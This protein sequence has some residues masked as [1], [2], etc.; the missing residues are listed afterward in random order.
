MFRIFLLLILVFT[1]LSCSTQRNLDFS[2][3]I[4]FEYSH[5]GHAW[6]EKVVPDRWVTEGPWPGPED[7]SDSLA[8]HALYRAELK[9]MNSGTVLYAT[10]FNS[11]FG[12]YKTT[13]DGLDSVVQIFRES[14]R[15]PKPVVS[16]DLVL[17]VW[18]DSLGIFHPMLSLRVPDS[19][20]VPFSPPVRQ[21]GRDFFLSGEP[22]GK[23]DV[24]ILGDGY[25][26]ADTAKFFN[27]AG[28]L[29]GH[30]FNT[31]PFLSMKDRF[32]L[33]AAM[34]PSET[35]GI[36]DPVNQKWAQGPLGF[37][38]NFFN[39]DRYI[40]S[41]DPGMIMNLAASYPWDVLLVLV[42]SRKYGGG[43][44]YNLYAVSASDNEQSPYVFIHEFGHSFAG[45][46]DEYYTS[47]I[48]YVVKA[49][50]EPREPNLSSLPGGRPKWESLLS[51]GVRIPTPWNQSGYDSAMVEIQKK[52]RELTAS[53][54][55][56]SE[57]EALFRHEKQ[58]TRFFLSPD[59]LMGITGAFEGGGYLAKGVY[60]PE[61][62]CIMFSRN[63]PAFCKVCES[64]IRKRIEK[65]S[66]N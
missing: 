42:N 19:G 31:E 17:S 66:R 26:E 64:E 2:T 39:S 15:F 37:T 24:L 52:R 32:N 48:A 29:S 41:S 16:A 4:R 14:V 63:R 12:E 35:E 21:V 28:R 47:Q 54:A 6:E 62:D 3:T 9:I 22:Q 7:L 34:I 44:I 13:Q 8:G 30:L 38:Y 40:L 59:S 27:D 23:V 57:M 45:L 5:V 60:R 25:T 61:I 49:G 56:V 33:R 36:P 51:P 55:P 46:G 10:E 18:N 65:L 43:G 20:L 11:I 50:P 1:G 53:G 58:L